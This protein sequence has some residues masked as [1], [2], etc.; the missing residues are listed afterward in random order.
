MSRRGTLLSARLT[1]FC[2][3]SAIAVCSTCSRIGRTNSSASCTIWFA[4]FASPMMSFRI[5]CASG[6]S[7]DAAASAGRP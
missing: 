6:E 7:D 4:I 1:A 3:T 2:S 5:D